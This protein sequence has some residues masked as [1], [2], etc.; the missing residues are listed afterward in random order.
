MA[1]SCRLRA[2]AQAR[3]LLKVQR[4]HSKDNGR[5]GPSLSAADGE[6]MA[7]RVGSTRLRLLR[8]YRELRRVLNQINGA[9]VAAAAR[10]ASRPQRQS[11]KI[12]T[13]YAVL[14]IE[15]ELTSRGR[16]IV[17][18]ALGIVTRRAETQSGSVLRS[19]RR[20][21]IEPGPSEGKRPVA[22]IR[23]AAFHLLEIPPLHA[24]I[25]LALSAADTD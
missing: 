1:R 10:R 2:G 23:A 9:E 14:W 12:P 8:Q 3:P 7:E 25:P 22:L 15:S 11:Q 20:S 17:L 4:T 24:A 6:P 21:R 19:R 16:A 13:A 18:S 5:L